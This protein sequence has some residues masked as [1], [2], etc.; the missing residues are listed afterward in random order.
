MSKVL[1]SMERVQSMFGSNV[2]STPAGELVDKATSLSLTTEDWG[3]NI[4]VCDAIN[5]YGD[6]A[7]DAVK[8]IKK[9]LSGNKN[10]MQI[11]LTLSLLETCVK[12]CGSRF[13]VLVTTKDF[14]CDILLKLIHAKYNPP[15]VLQQRVLGMIKQWAEAFGSNPVNGARQ[16]YDELKEKGYDFPET[17]PLEAILKSADKPAKKRTGH[18]SS[19]SRPRHH[20][21]SPA[22][23]SASRPSQIVNPSPQQ[24]DKIR[25]DL[26]VV[27]GNAKVFSEMLTELNPSHCDSS[28]YELLTELNR[29]CHAMQQRIMELIEQIGSEEMTIELLKVNDDLNNIFLRHERFEKFRANKDAVTSKPEIPPM[30]MHPEGVHSSS[31]GMVEPP[32]S[33]SDTIQPTPEVND[34][35]DLSAAE[36]IPISKPSPRGEASDLQSLSKGLGDINLD[37][38]SAS[39]ATPASY[40]ML[41][42]HLTMFDQPPAEVEQLGASEHEIEQWLASDGDAI[43]FKP[44]AEPAPSQDTSVTDE[45]SAFLSERATAANKLPN[46]NS[47]TSS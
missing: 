11:S 9:R 15:V 43:G 3:L 29:T 34:L 42:E 21:Q 32:P 10:F 19:Q 4:Q 22:H 25:T 30:S 6:G 41:S 46:V 8:A 17:E 2:F 36:D 40:P 23:A 39:S 38:R 27:N 44:P 24:L 45:F 28:D 5:S 35:I 14:C 18:H 26:A 31:M 37:S 47:S 16:V 1:F 20:N 33:Y 13:H 12:N 7:K